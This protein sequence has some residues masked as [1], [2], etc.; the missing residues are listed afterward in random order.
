MGYVTVIPALGTVLVPLEIRNTAERKGGR[1]KSTQRWA[2]YLSQRL[3]SHIGPGGIISHTSPASSLS[4]ALSDPTPFLARD[5]VKASKVVWFGSAFRVPGG[6]YKPV[7]RP[8]T[9]SSPGI[10]QQEPRASPLRVLARWS[11]WR[12]EVP[13]LLWSPSHTP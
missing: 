5:V 10:C 4:W 1:V 7:S 6:K 2:A 13:G 11:I 8:R 9:E 3:Q 12:D